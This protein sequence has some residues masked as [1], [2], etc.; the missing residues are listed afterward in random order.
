MQ[1]LRFTGKLLL[2][3]FGLMLLPSLSVS[4]QS[5]A[6]KARHWRV[7]VLIPEQHLER[8]R[9]PDPAAETMI[10]KQLIVADY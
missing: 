3:C 7:I 9:I 2:L 4:A 10:C 5:D 6:Q 1:T 8:P